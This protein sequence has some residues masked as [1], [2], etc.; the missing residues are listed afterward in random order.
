MTSYLIEAET[1]IEFNDRIRRMLKDIGKRFVTMS[2]AH[3][4]DGHYGSIRY[5]AIIICRGEGE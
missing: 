2:I 3:Y 4:R 1:A 5:T